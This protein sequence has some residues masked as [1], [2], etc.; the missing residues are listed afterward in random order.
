[1]KNLLNSLH[2]ELSKPLWRKANLWSYF[3]SNWDRLSITRS[4]CHS[5]RYECSSARARRCAPSSWCRRCAQVHHP[6]L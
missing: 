6:P 3:T 5:I 1:M 2:C 4:L